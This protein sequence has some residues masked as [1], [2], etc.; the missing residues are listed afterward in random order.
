MNL[1]ATLMFVGT[2]AFFTG[3][4]LPKLPEPPVLPGVDP[5][6][7]KKN[8]G[9]NPTG[10]QKIITKFQ[11]GRIVTIGNMNYGKKCV[12]AID[13]RTYKVTEIGVVI[14]DVCV[15][16]KCKKWYDNLELQPSS[17][18][19]ERELNSCKRRIAYSANVGYILAK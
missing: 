11:D 10:E 5:N 16:E 13:T 15:N 14:R 9:G 2:I 1:K 7:G 4:T 3:C 12:L 17:P 8:Y 19:E 18:E 6:I